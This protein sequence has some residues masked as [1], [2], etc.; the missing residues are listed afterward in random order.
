LLIQIVFYKAQFE[1]KCVQLTCI[2]FFNIFWIEQYVAMQQAMV[3]S[4]YMHLN[5]N[6]VFVVYSVHVNRYSVTKSTALHYKHLILYKQVL[7]SCPHSQKN[8]E[9]VRVR[10]K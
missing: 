7:Q 5:N 3:S 8:N 4:S 9:N 1:E 2:N 6:K 10:S